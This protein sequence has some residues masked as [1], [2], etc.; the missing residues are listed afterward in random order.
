[1]TGSDTRGRSSS[2]SW[3][4]ELTI[5]QLAPRRHRLP[6]TDFLTEHFSASCAGPRTTPRQTSSEHSRKHVQA[7]RQAPSAAP[8][9]PPTRLGLRPHDARGPDG[10]LRPDLCPPVHVVLVLHVRHEAVEVRRVRP[11][12]ELSVH[13][14]VRLDVGHARAEGGGLREVHGDEAR[15]P[16]IGWGKGGLR[17]REGQV[18]CTGG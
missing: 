12:R 13:L 5:L 6:R 8:P 14:E 4:T 3:M 1:M 10:A 15:D 7:R 9:H 2:P 18:G 17:V 11:R 16:L